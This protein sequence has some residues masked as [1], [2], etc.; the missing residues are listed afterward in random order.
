M[1][2]D[3]GDV[4]FVYDD[5]VTHRRY[6]YGAVRTV[7]DIYRLTATQ[8]DRVNKYIMLVM[9]IANLKVMARS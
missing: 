5:V 6:M 3:C 8:V 9:E 2:V 7:I 4:T 1:E